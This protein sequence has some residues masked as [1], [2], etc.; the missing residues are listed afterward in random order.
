VFIYY[1]ANLVKH[2]PS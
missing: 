2:P 1:G